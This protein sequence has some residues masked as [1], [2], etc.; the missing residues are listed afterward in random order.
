MKKKK[1]MLDL[2]L[3]HNLNI[4]DKIRKIEL[5]LEKTYNINL[6][7]PFYDSKRDDIKK[8]DTGQRTRWEIPIEEC[9]KLVRRDL[10]NITRRDGLLT[11]IEKPSIGTTLE[12]AHTRQ[13][14]K[15]I[16]VISEKFIYHPWIRVYADERFKNIEELELWLA[17]T[18]GKREE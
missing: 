1:N 12:I 5:Q 14:K 2:Y 3:A 18:V 8:I 9:R 7:N 10:A 15:L 17:D 11:I 13:K 4:R 16:I 6:H